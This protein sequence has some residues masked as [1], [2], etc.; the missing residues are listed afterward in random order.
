MVSQSNMAHVSERSK[1]IQRQITI[2]IALQAACPL[3]V[4]GLFSFYSSCLDD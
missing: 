2:T 1:A 4:T 3:I